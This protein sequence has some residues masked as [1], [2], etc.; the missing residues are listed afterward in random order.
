[1]AAGCQWDGDNSNL[2]LGAVLGFNNSEKES[3]SYGFAHPSSSKTAHNSKSILY[4]IYES[5]SR[6]RLIEVHSILA[7][8]LESMLTHVSLG[9]YTVL[10]TFKFFKNQH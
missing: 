2:S 4:F 5:Y 1:M 8:P 7:F 9:P 3:S 10:F 6:Q